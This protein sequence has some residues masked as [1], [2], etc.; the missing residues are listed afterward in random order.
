VMHAA[1]NDADAVRMR[2]LIVVLWRAGL[3]ISEALALNESDLDSSRGAILARHGK[4]GKRREVGMDRWAWGQLSPWLQLRAALPLGAL[5]CVLRGPPR[6]RPRAPAGKRRAGER[7]RWG[8][9]LRSLASSVP[10]GGRSPLVDTADRDLSSPRDSRAS[11]LISRAAALPAIVAVARPR[12][13]SRRSGRQ[14]AIWCRRLQRLTRITGAASITPHQAST[15]I[16]SGGVTVKAMG[17]ARPMLTTYSRLAGRSGAWRVLARGC[18]W[19]G[20]HLSQTLSRP[21]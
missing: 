6:G 1:G 14:G 3:R 7:C 9:G 5:F 17:V 16:S 12:K 11:W 20:T 10:A 2:G 13:R 8:V 18:C 21:S 4:G 15:P 19:I